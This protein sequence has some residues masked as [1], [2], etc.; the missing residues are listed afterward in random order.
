MT[1]PNRNNTNGNNKPKGSHT[2]RPQAAADPSSTEI[3]ASGIGTGAGYVFHNPRAVATVPAQL[4]L[5]CKECLRRLRGE[6]LRHTATTGPTSFAPD[7][8]TNTR[9]P[10]EESSDTSSAGTTE[11]D[12]SIAPQRL[13]SERTEPKPQPSWFSTTRRKFLERTGL[14]KRKCEGV[15]LSILLLLP[16]VQVY[17]K[18]T[19]QVLGDTPLNKLS[20]SLFS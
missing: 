2:R 14:R 4:R 9:R 16:T 7:A 6:A 1:D 13:Q 3:N 12:A 10:D 8:G 18:L 20:T 19:A 17:F 15:Y 5:W 11:V